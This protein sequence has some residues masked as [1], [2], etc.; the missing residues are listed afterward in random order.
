MEVPT[1]FRLNIACFI[2]LA[3]LVHRREAG[4]VPPKIIVMK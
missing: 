3:V 4:A 1:K 2:T